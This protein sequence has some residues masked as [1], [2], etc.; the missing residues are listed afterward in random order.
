VTRTRSTPHQVERLVAEVAERD[1]ALCFQRDLRAPIVRME[2]EPGSAGKAL[3]DLYGRNVLTRYDFRGV[4]SSGPKEARA[5]PV[6]SRAEAG[7]L[8]L[9][10]GLWNNDFVDELASFPYGRHDDQ[11]DALAGAFAVLA[12]TTNGGRARVRRARF[13]R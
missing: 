13:G 8:L 6:S 11:V 12:Q 9:V 2:Q 1:K 10:R 7:H 5:A 3:I 4:I